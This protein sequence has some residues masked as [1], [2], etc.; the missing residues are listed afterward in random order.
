[1]NDRLYPQRPIIA[2]SIAVFREGRVLLAAR[3]DTADHP[4]FSLPGGLVEI[5]ETLH[6]AALREL[7]EEVRVKARIL[8]FVDHVEFIERDDTA[9]VKR[10]FVVNAFV[11]QWVE[12]EATTGPEAPQVMWADPHALGGIATTKGLAR[13]VEKA[14]ALY[15]THAVRHE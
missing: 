15:L 3:R 13:I 10:H 6:D 5:G 14:A 8:A 4:I 2:A 7:Y 9:N 1:M 12:G 11:G